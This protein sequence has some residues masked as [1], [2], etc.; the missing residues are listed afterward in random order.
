MIE[1]M[2]EANLA[3]VILTWRD[4][5]LTSKCV[6]ALLRSDVVQRIIVVDNESCGH[7]AQTFGPAYSRFLNVIENPENLGFAKG[8]NIGMKAALDGGASHL[9]II[10]NDATIEHGSVELLLATAL[11]VGHCVVAPRI[12]DSNGVAEASWGRLTRTM[13]IARNTSPERAHYFTWA[14]IV[15]PGT[16]IEE[17]GYL[18]ES[19]FMYYE[20]VEWG[21][22]VRELGIPALLEPAATAVHERSAS[23][24]TAGAAVQGYSAHGLMVLS[25]RRGHSGWG[26]ARMLARMARAYVRGDRAGAQATLLGGRLAL[27]GQGNPAWQRVPQALKWAARA[28][29]DS[30][31][32]SC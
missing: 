30:A 4:T 31:E 17:A 12:V 26:A 14:C 10:N 32:S 28:P 22:R 9:L 3:A 25:R 5:A 13:G 8:V 19:F 18:D 6:D 1:P 20:D 2:P 29:R 15:V 7:V 21:I 11:R 27:A 16:V 23:T 24:S